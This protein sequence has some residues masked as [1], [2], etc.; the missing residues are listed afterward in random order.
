MWTKEKIEKAAT[1]YA[2]NV[3]EDSNYNGDE[4]CYSDV[5]NAF[6]AGAKYIINNTQKETEE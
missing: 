3:V 1:K 5:K 2:D 4:Y 6:L